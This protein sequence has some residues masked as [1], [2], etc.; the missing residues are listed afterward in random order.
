MKKPF[1]SIG[2]AAIAALGLAGAAVAQE[3]IAAGAPV[4]IALVQGTSGASFDVYSKQAQ[5]GFEMGL[6]YATD[7][8][9]EIKGHPINVIYKDTQFKPDVARA[10]LAE[11]Y[12]DDDALIAIG[13]TSSGVRICTQRRVATSRRHRSFTAELTSLS[14][15]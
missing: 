12:G 4:T 9:M 13:G 14:S 2:L 7:G 1:Y 10:V 6:E 11:A 3:G 8:T 5:T 15:S